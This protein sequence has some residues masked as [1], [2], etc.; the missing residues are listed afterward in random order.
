MPPPVGEMHATIGREVAVGRAAAP[1]SKRLVV[2]RVD[3]VG[4]LDSTAGL[5]PQAM[6]AVPTTDLEIAARRSVLP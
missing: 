1:L 4:E 3:V 6:P 2:G 5:S